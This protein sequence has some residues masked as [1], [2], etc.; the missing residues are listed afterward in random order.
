MRDTEAQRI[1]AEA[2]SDS[3]IAATIRRVRTRSDHKGYQ[4]LLVLRRG[5]RRLHISQTQQWQDVQLLWQ[6]L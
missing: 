4:V 5:L 3:R 6:D 1:V 2:A